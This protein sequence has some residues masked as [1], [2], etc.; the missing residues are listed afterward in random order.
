MIKWGSFYVALPEAP[1]VY[2]YIHP[3]GK[4]KSCKCGLE[5]RNA[6]LQ[7]FEEGQREPGGAFYVVSKEAHKDTTLQ[8]FE[9]GQR[10]PGGAF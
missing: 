4:S 1:K 5:F 2:T 9:E 10:E 3:E 7:C 6:T 8:C